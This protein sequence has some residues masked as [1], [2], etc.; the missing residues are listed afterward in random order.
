MD[1]NNGNALKF[2]K[3]QYIKSTLLSVL[4]GE[5]ATIISILLFA[6]LLSFVDVPVIMYDVFVTLAA[7]FG[8]IVAGYFNGRMI[9]KNGYIV[10]GICGV[11]ISI[12]LIAL[13]STFFVALPY[14]FIIVKILL[15]ILFSACG[16]ILGVNHKTKPIKY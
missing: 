9:K 14:S 10:G 5:I 1:N 3:F 15:V 6:F 11:I 8:G 16:G 12:I 13:K 7:L 2:D 4:F